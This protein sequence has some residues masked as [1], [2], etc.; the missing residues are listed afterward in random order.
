MSTAFLHI[1]PSLTR[2]I[3]FPHHSLHNSKLSSFSLSLNPNLTSVKM[4]TF[5]YSPNA[6][7]SSLQSALSVLQ[8]SP[9]TWQSSVLSNLIIFVLG[10]PLLVSGLSLSGIAAAFLLGTLTWR[11]FGSSGF[12]LVASYFVI[13]SL[14]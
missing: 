11:A 3:Q 9:P 7:P 12:L 6:L 13:V 4:T 5:N 14:I 1:Q 2:R 10:S 8:S